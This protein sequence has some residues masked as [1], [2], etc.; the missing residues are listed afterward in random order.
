MLL[1]ARFSNL[2]S[3]NDFPSR[4]AAIPTLWGRPCPRGGLRHPRWTD[5]VPSLYIVVTPKYFCPQN[6]EGTAGVLSRTIWHKTLQPMAV[7]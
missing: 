1:D 7:Y 5:G 6:P 4:A 3:P 2:E